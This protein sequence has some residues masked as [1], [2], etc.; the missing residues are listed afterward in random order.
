MKLDLGWWAG[1][2]NSLQ[3]VYGKLVS[4]EVTME[5]VVWADAW[6]RLLD[7]TEDAGTRRAHRSTLGVVVSSIRG[8]ES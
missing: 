3:F 4:G 7:T 5:L 8:G 6:K 2:S 1:R